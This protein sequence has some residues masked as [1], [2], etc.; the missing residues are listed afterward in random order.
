[1]KTNTVKTKIIEFEQEIETALKTPVHL[2]VEYFLRKRFIMLGMMLL[3][4]AA[5]VKSDGKVLGIL[6]EAYN[7]GYGKVG[8]YLRNETVHRSHAPTH[9]RIIVAASQ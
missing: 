5:L 3:M 4:C 7:H 2:K 1:M 9:A 8:T 6:R